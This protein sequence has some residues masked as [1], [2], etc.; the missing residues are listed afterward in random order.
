[1][2]IASYSGASSVIKPGVVTSSTRPSSPFVG[3]LVYETD[4]ARVMSY[5]G[6][7]WVAQGGKTLINSASFANNSVTISG[8]PQTYKDLHFVVR[9]FLPAVGS[10]A[11]AFRFNGDTASRYNYNKANAVTVLTLNQPSMFSEATA[12]NTVSQGLM[13]GEIPDYT[14]T[15]TWKA[16]KFS[17]IN[18]NPSTTTSANVLNTSVGVYNQVDPITSITFFGN[19]GNI[20]SGTILLYGIN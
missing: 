2:G 5:N 7:A 1:M 12:S 20:T 9:N 8:I 4:T 13:W 16:M 3:Q 11:L 18:N 17:V 14:N 19:S 6:S 15:T 10:D